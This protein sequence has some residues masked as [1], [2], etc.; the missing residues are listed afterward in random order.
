[1]NPDKQQNTTT[2]IKTLSQQ[3]FVNFGLGHIAYVRTIKTPVG[4]L[5]RSC[6]ADGAALGTHASAKEAFGALQMNDLR[7]VRVH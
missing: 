5:W 2:L 1:M 7:P 6:A 4:S 3:D